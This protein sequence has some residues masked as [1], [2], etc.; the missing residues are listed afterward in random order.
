VKEPQPLAIV[1]LFADSVTDA[2]VEFV[3][4]GLLEMG[5]GRLNLMKGLPTKLAV[6]MP[7]DTN[8]ERIDEVVA[9]LDGAD[10][11][12]GV[13]VSYPSWRREPQK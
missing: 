5:F 3:R 7:P 10:H 13:R 9:F 8:R 4:S 2:D 12:D 11:V 6:S 1:A